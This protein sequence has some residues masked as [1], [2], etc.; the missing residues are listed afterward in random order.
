M[1]E[2]YGKVGKADFTTPSIEVQLFFVVLFVCLRQ[3]VDLP[4]LFFS[5]TCTNFPALLASFHM[6]AYICNLKAE[7]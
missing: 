7:K 4:K 3:S 5:Q 1:G 6:L 2:A